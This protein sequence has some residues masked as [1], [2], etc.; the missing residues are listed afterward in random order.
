MG[1]AIALV[2]SEGKSVTAFLKK[3]IFSRFDT[4]RAIIRDGESHFCNK[5][6]KELLKNMGFA[7]MWPV[8]TILKLVGKWRCQKVN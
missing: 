1:G 6:F 8:L 2:N 3:N 5:M 7:I 4:P